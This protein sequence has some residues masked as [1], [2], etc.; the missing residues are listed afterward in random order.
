[1]GHSAVHSAVQWG[2]EAD[3]DAFSSCYQGTIMRFMASFAHQLEAIATT[4]YLEHFVMRKT[5]K[6]LIP[7]SLAD[8]NILPIHYSYVTICKFAPSTY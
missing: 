7:I 5:R 2:F 1:M 6:L 8:A 4:F 3:R